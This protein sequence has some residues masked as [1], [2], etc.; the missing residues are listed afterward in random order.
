MAARANPESEQ[1]SLGQRL[2]KGAQDVYS[3]LNYDIDRQAREA[4]NTKAQPLVKDVQA[5]LDSLGELVIFAMSDDSAFGA[6]K[7]AMPN[8]NNKNS[9]KAPLS[10]AFLA[11]QALNAKLN[12][13]PA[14][15]SPTYALVSGPLN[16]FAQRLMN[17][18]SCQIQ[19]M[20]E[21]HVLAKARGAAPSQLQ[22]NLFADQ[23]GLVRDFADKTLE[24]ILHHTL[25]GYEP[26]NL[27]GLT[28]PFTTEFLAFLNSGTVGYQPVRDEYGVTVTALPTGV[29]KGAFE[30]PY[31]VELSLH[32]AREKQGFV[33]YNSPASALF[34]WRQDTCGDTS[35]V[36]RFK[37]ATLNVM[38]AGENGFLNFL[39]DFQYGRK[40]FQ[41]SDFPGRESVLG[42]L[43]ISDIT[44]QYQFSGA[45]ELINSH[46]VLAGEPPFTI[47]VC[48]R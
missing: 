44:V 10:L 2:K 24:Y 16:F 19:F 6:V 37:S 18:A 22:Q 47:S 26:E 15:D 39:S 29:N 48:Q 14:L 36:I 4:R 34:T 7:E 28:V 23:G 12:P 43:G 46:R 31:A 5:V 21:G 11:T 41:A 13:N 9:M 35:L 20:W 17:Q 45:D 27:F 25:G 38:Y 42:K 30:T 3:D 33:N 8:E 40:T 1:R 32:C